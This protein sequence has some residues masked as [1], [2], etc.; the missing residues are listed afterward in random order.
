MNLKFDYC[1]VIARLSK[2]RVVQN[3]WFPES[4]TAVMLFCFEQVQ[5]ARVV[6]FRSEE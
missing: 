3:R 2:W 6:L 5:L 1:E 4:A